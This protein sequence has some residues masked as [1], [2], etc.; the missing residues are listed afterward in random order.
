LILLPRVWLLPFY[1]AKDPTSSDKE[2][3]TL[4]CD[5]LKYERWRSGCL[6]AYKHILMG[7]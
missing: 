1:G 3:L 4:R 5:V 7:L 2:D 6:W